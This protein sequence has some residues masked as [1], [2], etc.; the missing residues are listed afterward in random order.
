MSLPRYAEYQDSGVEWLGQVPRHWDV[1]RLKVKLTLLT[2]RAERR[3]YPVALENVESWSGRFVATEGEFEGCGV[4]FGAG[5]ILFGKLRPYLAKVYLAD[6]AGEAVGDF[7][8]LRPAQSMVGRFVQYQILNQS[9][10]DVID[11]STFGSKMPRASWESLGDMPLTVP[12]RDEQ[13]VIAAFLDREAGKI[14]ALIAGQEKLL[15]LLA[16]KRRATISRAVRRGLNPDAPTKDSGVAWLGPVPTHWQVVPLRWCSQCKS[17]DGIS[18]TDIEPLADPEHGTPAI[19]G[20]GRMGF[21]AAGNV[22]RPVLAIGRVGALCGNVHVVHPPAWISDNALMLTPSDAFFL[23]FLAH[24]L[25][26]RNLNEIAAKTA[27]PLITGT[28][29]ADQRVPLPPMVEQESIAEF[30]SYEV[31]KLESL[32]TEAERAIALLKERRSALIAA[33]VTGQIDVRGALP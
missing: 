16:E 8:V 13:V 17:G 9:F 7:H 18:S 5:D 21:T 28:Q 19:G 11:G 29:V 3:S 31:G 25:R 24:T 23:E 32:K 27:Q 10:I 22:N 20:N 12:P 4:A 6:H 1:R 2:E 15:A 26:S 30:I 14:D 33:A